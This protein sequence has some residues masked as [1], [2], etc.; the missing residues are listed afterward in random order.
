MIFFA[1]ST[2]IFKINTDG[3]GF[4]RIKK[5]CDSRNYAYPTISK[6]KDKIIWQR[7]DSRIEGYNTHYSVIRLVEM[8]LDGTEER[9]IEID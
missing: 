8:N 6:N 7:T 4:Q 3:S 2:G 9:I 5:A 1:N